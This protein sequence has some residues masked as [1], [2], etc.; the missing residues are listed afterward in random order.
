MAVTSAQ[1]FPL[2]AAGI[3]GA[4]GVTLGALG[5]HKLQPMLLER[6]MTRSWETGSKYHL[7]HTVAI[8]AIAA[9]CRNLSAGEAR[10]LT[11]AAWLWTVGTVLFS[12]SLY[13]YAVGGPRPLVYVT[14]VGGVILIAG[15]IAVIAAAFDR[16]AR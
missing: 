7:L 1:R 11:L 12:F 6:G 10:R 2:L 16:P 14:P 8:L 9:L 15:W 5:A 13:W 4:L 3:L